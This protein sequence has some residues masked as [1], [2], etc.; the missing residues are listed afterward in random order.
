M[1]VEAIG[2]LFGRPRPEPT[3]SEP[4]AAAIRR[5]QEMRAYYQELERQQHELLEQEIAKRRLLVALQSP[6]VRSAF[7]DIIREANAGQ[8]DACAVIAG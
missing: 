5:K 4:L 2:S 6:E 3:I 8:K 1:I 7:I